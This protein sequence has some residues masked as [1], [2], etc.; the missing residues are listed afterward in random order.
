VARK[1]LQFPGG[2]PPA[3]IFTRIRFRKATALSVSYGVGKSCSTSAG[4]QDKIA[5]TV[6]HCNERLDLT[7]CCRFTHGLEH[8]RASTN[9]GRVLKHGA[10]FSRDASEANTSIRD[11]RFVGRDNIYA[12]L[13]VV[14]NQLAG[15]RS[16]WQGIDDELRSKCLDRFRGGVQKCRRHSSGFVLSA[17]AHQD[18][19]HPEMERRT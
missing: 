11:H 6:E 13:K 19:D 4:I 17:I 14:F 15:R 10:G 2:V 16:A 18:S 8:R 1:D 3:Q 12:L 9:S 5:G 7:A